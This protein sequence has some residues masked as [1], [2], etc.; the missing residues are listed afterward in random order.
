[1]ATTDYI[2]AINVLDLAAANQIALGPIVMAAS[3]S[4][5]MV[6]AEPKMVAGDALVLECSQEQAEA[7]CQVIRLKYQKHQLRCY[8]KRGSRWVRI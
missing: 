4:R 1:M 3:P 8:Q 5:R 6:E 7:I 2:Y